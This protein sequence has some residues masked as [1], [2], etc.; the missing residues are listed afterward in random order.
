MLIITQKILWKMSYQVFT[1][2]T[3]QPRM[4]IHIPLNLGHIVVYSRVELLFRE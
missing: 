1:R 3:Y 2:H 4:C